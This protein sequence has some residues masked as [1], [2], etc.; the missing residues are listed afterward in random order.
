M[1][2]HQGDITTLAVDA[3]VNAAN[4][5]L[6]GGGGVDG[7]IHKAAGP[8][9]LCGCIEIGGCEVG[10]ARATIGYKLPC[11]YIIH[12]VGPMWGGGH[13]GEPDLLRSAYRS[14]L[15][16]ASSLGAHSVA[17]PCISTGVYGYP[18]ELAAPIA[19]EECA[20]FPHLDIIFC[21]TKETANG[22]R[23]R[24]QSHGA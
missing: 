11:E 8:E 17:F 12:A 21:C 4:P 18:N 14:S 24:L 23:T 6:M 1:R 9:L 3:I 5:T 13:C 16:L 20:K 19:I 10:G 15:E 2:V 22:Y 7:A